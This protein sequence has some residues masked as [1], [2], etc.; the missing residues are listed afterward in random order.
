MLLDMIATTSRPFGSYSL[1]K[2]A[3]SERMCLTNGQ[4]LQIKATSSAGLLLKSASKTTLPL[5]SGSEN[6]GNAVPRSSMVDGVSG[7]QAPSE[8]RVPWNY[9]P[10]VSTR[11]PTP[12]CRSARVPSDHRLEL[13]VPHFHMLPKRGS[14]VDATAK[15]AKEADHGV[16][17]AQLDDAAHRIRAVRIC[18]SGFGCVERCKAAVQLLQRRTG[19]DRGED[20]IRPLRTSGFERGR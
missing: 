11:E 16:R 4:C 5:K 9:S 7:M 12:R 10:P 15:I 3:N 19:A 20:C 6:D 17:A 2:R 13:L 8:D 18:H 1:A 14:E